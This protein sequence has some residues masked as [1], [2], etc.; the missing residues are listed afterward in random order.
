MKGSANL[1]IAAF[2]IGFKNFAVAIEGVVNLTPECEGYEDESGNKLECEL[3]RDIILADT[4]DITQFSTKSELRSKSYFM[5]AIEYMDSISE[6]MDMCDVILIEQ[7][8]QRNCKAVKLQQNLHTYL[9]T[10]YRRDK[11]IIIYPST[12][13]T[14]AF[15]APKMTKPQRKKWAVDKAL[16][17]LQSM[18]SMFFDKIAQMKKRDDVC[19]CVLMIES[20]KMKS[21][22]MNPVG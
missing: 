12:N 4:T 8:L 18:N 2:D 22:K 15:D 7:Q 13:K 5:G 16:D 21:H 10:K 9:M 11:K 20:Y 3:R 17:I 14:R 19:D 6:Y 1:V